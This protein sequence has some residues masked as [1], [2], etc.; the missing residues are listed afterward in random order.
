MG[1]DGTRVASS[2]LEPQTIDFDSEWGT[3]R[4]Y[5]DDTL[6][7]RIDRKT[8]SLIHGIVY[9]IC[10]AQPEPRSNEL[11]LKMSEYLEEKTKE[12]A[13]RLD[14]FQGSGEKYT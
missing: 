8:Y 2:G 12:I 7:G 4:K 3:L 6:L 14:E 13:K 5:L 9:R 10:I 11:Y 1:G